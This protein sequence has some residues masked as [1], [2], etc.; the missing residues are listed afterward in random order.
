MPVCMW[1]GKSICLY[2]TVV[3]QSCSALVWHSPPR[4]LKH[5]KLSQN[6]QK[7]RYPPLATQY[8]QSKKKTAWQTLYRVW[9][10]RPFL[11][12]RTGSISTPSPPLHSNLLRLLVFSPPL[13]LPKSLRRILVHWQPIA[14]RPACTRVSSGNVASV[15]S[16]SYP[17]PVMPMFTQN[18]FAAR[19]ARASPFAARPKCSRRSQEV[20]GP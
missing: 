14:Q 2:S 16:D 8:I 1:D 10:F 5:Y 19:P 13:R 9:A 11:V 18:G 3:M 15:S 20:L 12:H 7:V 6:S 17:Q 4:S